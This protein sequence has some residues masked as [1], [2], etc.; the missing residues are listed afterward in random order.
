LVVL[1]HKVEEQKNT[2]YVVLVV[3]VGDQVTSSISFL[4][5]FHFFRSNPFVI[6]TASSERTVK[7]RIN[8]TTTTWKNPLVVNQ[9]ERLRRRLGRR[10]S[11]CGCPR[12]KA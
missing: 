5:T 12:L 6:A 4:L 7:V 3:S 1:I 11:T 9:S 2:Y 8:K 10:R